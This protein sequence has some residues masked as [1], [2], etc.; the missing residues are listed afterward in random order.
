[1]DIKI[2][3][4]QSIL[5]STTLDLISTEA[6]KQAET[7][8][9]SRIAEAPV[10]VTSDTAKSLQA[11]EAKAN[12]A[13]VGE[14]H[15]EVDR[16]LLHQL[17]QKPTELHFYWTFGRE[18]ENY[19]VR[20]GGEK[21]HERFTRYMD[22]LLEVAPNLLTV[23]LA[24][25][26]LT[27]RANQFW[28]EPLQAKYPNRLEVRFVCDA[29]AKLEKA[30]PGYSETIQHVF[31]NASQGNPVIASD[32][33]RLLCMVDLGNAL[34]TIFIYCDVDTFVYGCDTPNFE[35]QERPQFDFKTRTLRFVA[36][37]V[38]VPGHSNLMK[39]LF[40]EPSFD[41]TKLK[42]GFFQERDP[43]TSFF[44]CRPMER[45]TGYKNNDIVKFKV[46]DVEA[47]MDFSDDI[48]RNLKKHLSDD[49][50]PICILNYFT[51]LHGFV[52]DC[53]GKTKEAMQLVF[54]DYLKQFSCLD[55]QTSD[56][57]SVTGPGLLNKRSECSSLGRVHPRVAS[58]EWH[59]TELLQGN[60]PGPLEA[61]STCSAWHDMQTVFKAYVSR[62]NDA[63]YAK[64]FG[65]N[66]PFYLALKD[67]LTKNFPYDTQSFEDLLKHEYDHRQ[68][69]NI[70]VGVSYKDWK[71]KHLEKIKQ[72]PPGNRP[73]GPDD[74]YYAR[75]VNIL[76]ALG[77]NVE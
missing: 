76:S 68:E 61:F 77:I 6:Q 26:E 28:I 17:I 32:I 47:Y 1:M 18:L 35:L 13:L 71:I 56:V 40:R 33:Y 65:E 53:E 10:L 14:T 38:E 12:Q 57:I 15:L 4:K 27:L 3:N 50:K 60:V 75:L 30:F 45:E 22:K 23:V 41:S 66:H 31:A 54:G 51:T 42:T 52:K 58:W 59:G 46:Q 11:Y 69:S 43:N 64:K 2:K 44:L 19:P 20:I 39:A 73:V 49:T 29:Q 67:H 62:L 34:S 70:D 7:N 24:L 55:V 37:T 5:P 72:K 63:L 8:F 74:S 25:D 48:L 21:Y 9:S 36:E 16:D